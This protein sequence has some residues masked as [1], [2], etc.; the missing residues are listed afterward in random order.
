M[1]RVRPQIG[2]RIVNRKKIETSTSDKPPSLSL[3]LQTEEDE[4]QKQEINPIKKI[5]LHCDYQV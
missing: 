1:Q 4:K 2:N 5:Y 3:V